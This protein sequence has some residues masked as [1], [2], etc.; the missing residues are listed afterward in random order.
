MFDAKIFG[1]AQIMKAVLIEEQQ[2]K[3]LE[4]EKEGGQRSSGSFNIV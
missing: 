1:D 4:I 2:E 3:K